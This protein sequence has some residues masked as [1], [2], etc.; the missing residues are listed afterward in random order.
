[1][2]GLGQN[3]GFV[4]WW[5]RVAESDAL[6]LQMLWGAGAVFYARTTEP[7]SLMH[8]ECSSNLYGETANP[9]NR[10]LTSGGST[11]GEGALLALRGSC[12]GIGTDIGGSIRNP[13]SNC[14]VYGYKPTSYRLPLMGCAATMIGQEHIVPTIGPLSTSLEGCKVFMKTL[15][16]QKPWLRSPDLLPFPWRDGT[17]WLK[18]VEGRKKVKIGVMWHDG[19]VKPHPPVTRALREM[20]EKLRKVDGVEVVDWKPWKHDYAWDILSSLYFAD[21]GKEEAEA[22][23][24]SGEPWRP[25]STFIIKEQKMVKELSMHE[26]WRWTLQREIYR[27]QYAALWNSTGG[28]PVDVILCPAGPGAAPPLDHARYWGYMAQWNLLDYPAIC[29]PVT[30]VDQEMD[31]VESGFRAMGEQDEWNWRLYRPERYVDAPVGLQLVGKRYEDEK[32]F[33]VLEWMERV[34][35]LP[36]GEM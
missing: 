25:M 8:L 11:G 30:K 13:A 22:I 7:Q 32:V 33:E 16:G 23:N 34:V 28:D 5:D 26:L 1:M 17:E 4:S 19:V 29:F 10:A 9:Y 14:G 12:L 15:V 24:V 21:G 31:R 35:G 2:A 36:F 20:V 27:A 6:I 3:G 18:T